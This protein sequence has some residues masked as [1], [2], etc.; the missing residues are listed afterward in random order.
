M[1]ATHRSGLRLRKQVRGVSIITAIFMLLLFAALAAWMASLL[2]TANVTSAQD[3]Q[4]ARAYHAAQAGIEWGL[5]QV[6][7]SAV[8]DPNAAN[9]PL[10]ATLGEFTVVVNCTALGPY[11]DGAQTFTLYQ[12]TATARNAVAA[13]SSGYVERQ[14]S[15]SVSR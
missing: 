14:V 1:I 13:G 11:V 8:C 10:P 3:V 12:L 2:T 5:Y 9:T 15:A 7:V 6:Q 4:G